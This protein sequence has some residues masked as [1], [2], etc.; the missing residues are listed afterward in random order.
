MHKTML[1]ALI[2]GASA[3]SIPAFAQVRLGGAAQ[4]GAGANAAAAAP[5]AMHTADQTGMRAAQTLH[6][7]DQRARHVTRRAV[8][9]SRSTVNNNASANV[10]AAGSMNGGMANTNAGAN[11]DIG[12]GVNATNA[13]GNVGI[14]GQ[15]VGGD[16]RDTAHSAIGATDRSAGSVGNAVRQTATGQSVGADAKVDAA[17]AAHGH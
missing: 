13:A 12:A 11:V 8:D 9:R 7:A 15:G 16:V 17:A 10:D 5:G 1:A 14:P 6:R 3:L 4:V 2:V